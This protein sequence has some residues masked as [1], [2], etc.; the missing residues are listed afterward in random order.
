[1]SEFRELIA[2]SQE[3]MAF[4]KWVVENHHWSTRHPLKTMKKEI[5]LS[6]LFSY[7]NQTG[8]KPKYRWERR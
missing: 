5:L 7:K 3:Y 4:K 2:G 1:M 6:L 8:S